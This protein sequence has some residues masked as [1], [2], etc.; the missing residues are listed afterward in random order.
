MITIMGIVPQLIANSLIAGST[1][2]LITLGFNLMYGTTKFVNM[3]YGVV[4]AVGGYAVFF[5]TVRHGMP[6]FAGIFIGVV[7]AGLLGYASDRV[8]FA[9]LR[10]RK[11]SNIVL[12]IASLGVFTVL[13]AA[14]AMLFTPQFQILP[15]P[16]YLN[17]VY[18][19][20]GAAVTRV[21]IV[22]IALGVLLFAGIWWMGAKTMFGKAVRAISD[23]AEVAKIVGIDVEQ[24]VG[25]VFFVGSA[26]AGLAGIMI[27]LDTGIQ[28]TMGLLVLLE[29]AISSIIGGIGNIYGGVLGSF[30]LG[31]AEN[32]GIW[33]IAA[34]WK[35]AISFGLLIIFLIFR[36]RGILSR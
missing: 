18:E 33:K 19:I 11:A 6:A 10:R 8:V 17:G 20:G 34:E 4:A 23:D 9:P 15:L 12:F 25:G 32:F 13:Q 5:F 29:G 1:Y 22:I 26:I 14:L 3:A 24:T 27:G 35:S 16:S 31:F 2:V 28:P 36:P 30:L 21:Q 7:L